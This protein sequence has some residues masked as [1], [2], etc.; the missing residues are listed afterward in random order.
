MLGKGVG[1]ALGSGSG[2]MLGREGGILAG[3][4]WPLR[5]GL[6]IERGNNKIG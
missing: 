6:T 5:G 4:G 3:R 2:G 1:A